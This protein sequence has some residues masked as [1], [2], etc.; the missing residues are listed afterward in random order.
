MKRVLGAA[1]LVVLAVVLTGGASARPAPTTVLEV[2]VKGRGEV[3]TSDGRLGCR[4]RCSARYRRGKV[5]TLIAT[6]DPN[7][8]FDRWEGACLGKAPICDVAL[9]GNTSVRARFV[10]V[11]TL[12]L[13]S[14]GGPGRVTSDKGGINCGEASTACILEL[15]NSTRV[16]LTPVAGTRGRFGGWDGPCAAA[17]TAPCVL[18]IASPRTEVAAAFG[19]AAPEAGQQTLS[20]RSAGAP[21]T[22]DPPG[23]DCPS[24]TCSASFPSGMTVTLRRN[25]G[26]WQPACTGLSARCLLVVDAPTEVSVAPPPPPAPPPPR[27]PVVRLLVTV[28]GGGLVTSKSRA[29]SCGWSSGRQDRCHRRIWPF[30]TQVEQLRAKTRGSVQLWRWGGLCRRREPICT[31]RMIREPNRRDQDFSVTALFRRG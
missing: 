13:L 6:P 16:T 25:G 22:S 10:G 3:K 4:S 12:L 28:S 27:L 2:A 18:R 26:V 9:D 30:G 17:G 7:F 21:V 8:T 31:A 19:H 5:L 20:I 29:I 11:P 23:I 1:G 15:P 14:V 24:S